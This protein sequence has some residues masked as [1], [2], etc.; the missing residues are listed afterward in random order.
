MEDSVYYPVATTLF[1]NITYAYPD[2]NIWLTG[3]S[4]GGALAS[5][6][7]LT[8]G[9]PAITFESPGDRLPSKR[10]HLPQIPSE[11]TAI[12]HVYHTADPVA[13]GTCN[14]ILSPCN[15]AGFAMETR[16]HTGMSIVYDTV[17]KFGWAV[18]L[19]HHRIATVIN[20]ILEHD[21]KDDDGKVYVPKPETEGEWGC[22]CVRE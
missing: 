17:T 20:E 16:C 12:Y 6:L 19:R 13:Q 22:C 10:L 2:S 3:H 15:A 11:M 7:G 9:V 8:F 14:G 4:L 1:N 18:D 5:M 21:W